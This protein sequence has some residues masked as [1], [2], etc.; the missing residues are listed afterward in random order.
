MREPLSSRISFRILSGCVLSLV[1]TLGLSSGATAQ[2]IDLGTS[3]EAC[4]SCHAAGTLVPVSDI[5]NPWDAHYTDLN[6]AGPRT[7]S[8]YRQLNVVVSQVDLRGS[9]VVMEFSVMDEAAGAVTNLF[10][11]DG[12]FTLA[13]LVPGLATGDPT[14]WQNVV[15]GSSQRFT[16]AG[17]SFETLGNGNYRYTS[18]LDPA[19]I[20]LVDGQTLRLAIQISASDLPAGNGWCDFDVALDPVVVAPNDCVSPAGLTRDITQT[21]SCNSC[22]GSTSDTMLSFHGGGRTEVEYC[23]TCH[24]PGIGRTDMTNMVHKIHAGKQLTN[25]VGWESYADVGYTR[26]LDN[27]LSCHGGGGLD[28]DNWQFEPNRTACGS[29]HDDVDF[30]SGAGH[31][32]V[33]PQTTNR[34]CGNCHPA[35]GILTDSLLPTSVV[36][37]GVA[38]ATE[39]GFYRGP[40]NGFSIDALDYDRQTESL[41]FDFSVTRDNQKQILQTDPKW[42]NGASLGLQIGWSSDEYTN[43][44][45]GSSPAP[46]QPI[47]INGLDVGGAVTDLGGGN[48]RSVVDI[49][50]FGFGNLTLAME[51]H[52]QADILGMGTYSRIPVRDVFRDVNVELRGQVE[53]RRA[54]V[55]IAKCNACHDGSGAGLDFHGSNRTSEAQTCVL[56]H[57]PDAT[58]IQRRPVDPAT[59]LDGKR[60]E[61][62]DMKRM[63]HGIHAGEDLAQGLVIYGFGS[64]PTDYSGIGFI[65][66]NANCLSCH[67]PGTYSTDAASRTLASTVD[68]GPVRT[69]PADD[70]NISPISATCSS[71]HDDV[72]ATNHMLLNGGSFQALD[73]NIVVPEANIWM[74]LVAGSSALA[75]L[76]RRRRKAE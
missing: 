73:E 44:G 49:S 65:G 64:V 7:D 68:T 75:M 36:H 13:R 29:C 33:G 60:E 39:A 21:A 63:I 66:N 17:G 24:N 53:P 15:A 35:T 3:V 41:T 46:A 76:G 32:I 22:H 30:D 38:R 51:G 47:R 18:T 19:T 42:S 61:S 58:D 27:C 26:D 8:S 48:Y 34:F 37:Q 50:S 5:N 10:D 9:Q 23:V 31:G 62:I 14:E 20:P 6:P 52:P 12:R 55:D 11:S 69:D 54:V 43:E 70:L 74:A 16:T 56:C 2:V 71:C 45:S 25:P 40:D 72:I 57:N 28:E 67:Y 1:I 59:S 4:I